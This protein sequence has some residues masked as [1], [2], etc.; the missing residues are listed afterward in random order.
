MF[1]TNHRRRIYEEYRPFLFHL[2]NQQLVH[3]NI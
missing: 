1:E 2:R 3:A